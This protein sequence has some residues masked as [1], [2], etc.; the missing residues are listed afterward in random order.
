MRLL[1]RHWFE[2]V[3]RVGLEPPTNGL[4]GRCSTT[5]LPT[6]QTG[7]GAKANQRVLPAQGI[8]CQLKLSLHASEHS[9]PAGSE[10][11]V[12]EI[13]MQ[14]G[15]SAFPSPI[16]RPPSPHEPPH[17]F[18]LPTG[19]ERGRRPGEGASPRLRGQCAKIFQ[20]NLCSRGTAGSELERGET[21]EN[22]LLSPAL[23]SSFGEERER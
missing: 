10:C 5:E 8:I 9:K 20:E 16:D 12:T 1:P 21:D 7:G 18:P 19:G 15:R 2:V 4:K 14:C 13:L 17:P 23:S 3:G 11:R 6:Q 22:G